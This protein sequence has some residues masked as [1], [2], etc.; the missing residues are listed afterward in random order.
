M[1]VI[2]ISIKLIVISIKNFFIY[3]CLAAMPVK[4]EI[5]YEGDLHCKAVHGP[6]GSILETDAPVENNGKC[7]KFSPTSFKTNDEN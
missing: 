5:E 3:F 2:R 7:E 1:D 4:I 6:S